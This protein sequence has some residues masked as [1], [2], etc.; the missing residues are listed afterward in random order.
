[1]S[2]TDELERTAAFRASAPYPSQARLAAGRDRLLAATTAE[3]AGR[4]APRQWWRRPALAGGLT[5]VAAGAAAAALVLT[6]GPAAVP[7]QH[8]TTGHANTVVTAAWTVRED[9]DGTVSIYLRQYTDPA[10]LQ[11]VLRADGVNA[12]V[13]QIP[14]VRRTVGKVTVVYDS[15]EFA[16]TDDA[17]QAVQLAVGVNIAY[18]SPS[19]GF[20]HIIHPSAMPRGSALLL[21][22]TNSTLKSG[23]NGKPGRVLGGRGPV[24]LNNDT[25]PACVPVSPSPA[26][27]RP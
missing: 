18:H 2:E 12:I 20:Y 23:K 7:G 27:F 9:A 14:E 25:V 11:K 16:T 24:V 8:G 13:R 15:C 10:G 22:F 5:V 17:P 21:A 1:M 19:K 6:G 4:A 26:W 3:Q